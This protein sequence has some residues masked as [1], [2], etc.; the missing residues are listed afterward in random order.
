MVQISFHVAFTAKAMQNIGNCV[1]GQLPV[2]LEGL[3]PRNFERLLCTIMHGSRNSQ[4]YQQEL[5]VYL[6]SVI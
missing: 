3:T 1:V 2:F 6:T 5:N 4:P